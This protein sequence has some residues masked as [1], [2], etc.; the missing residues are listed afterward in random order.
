[1]DNMI[2]TPNIGEKIIL[3]VDDS[4]ITRNLIEKV[5]KDRYKVLMASN[6]REAIDIVSTMPEGEII[7]ILLDLNMPDLDGFAVL[8]YFNQRDLFE[9]IP[10]SI[11][12]GD[13]SRETMNRVFSYKIVDV[14]IKP[15]SAYDIERVVS[16]MINK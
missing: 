8:D 12:T 11:I 13:N 3:V 15:F 7:A 2:L 9:K 4:N 16:K 1:M 14:L 5:Y 10:V 6:G